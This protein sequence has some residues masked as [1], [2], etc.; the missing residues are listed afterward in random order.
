M[1]S[2]KLTVRQEVPA[3]PAGD[4]NLVFLQDSLSGRSFLVDTGASISVFQQIAPTLSAPLYK[5]KLLTASC[6]PLPC[7]GARV[8]PLRFGSRYFSWSFQL[9]PVSIP[10]LGSDFLHRHALLVDVARAKVLDADSLDVLSVFSSPAAS[11]PFCAH[12]QQ[13]PRE[14]WKLLSEYP[15][16]LSSDVFLASTPKHG[17]FH[18]LPTAPGPPVFAKACRLDPEKLASV[19]AEFL[20]MEKA[21]IC[22]CSSS[23]LSSPL[24]MVPK[25]DG[26]WRPS[27]DFRRLNTATVPDRYPLTAIADFSARI[28]G[29]KFFSKLDLQKG[30]FQIP[31]HP[32]D[33]PKTAIITPFGLFEFLRLP[34]RLRNAAQTFQRMM[35]R[36][37]GDLPFCFVYLD[38]ILV[39]SNSLEDHQLHL[40]H[41][42]DLCCLHG[43][44]INLEKC[45]F[46]PSQVEYLENLVSSSGS[47]PL[48]KHL[49][50]ITAFPP[51]ADHPALQWFLGIVNFYR[52]VIGGA[53]LILRPLTA[54]RSQGLL[55]I[56][57]DELCLRLHQICLGSGAYPGTP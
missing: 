28:A 44:I 21:G 20:K 11:N 32:A 1:G 3:V 56:P 57:P 34:F 39:F 22:Q 8:I 4:F 25:P 16:F 53:A 51:T 23:T 10:I 12:L 17:V 38:D 9:A 26:T 54:W 5:T 43:L 55:L 29:P 15:D 2:G 24:H 40:R 31:M 50:A 35:D 6:S 13:A 37:F 46:A 36:I 42:L 48:H 47:A 52:K 49:S 45:V 19:K 33:I 7:F 30:Y 18:D 27:D 41:V 14:I